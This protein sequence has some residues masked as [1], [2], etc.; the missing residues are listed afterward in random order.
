MYGK[1]VLLLLVDLL[2]VVTSGCPLVVPSAGLSVL[3][4]PY[5]L[6]YLFL[7][8]YFSAGCC[9]ILLFRY[10]YDGYFDCWQ[11]IPFFNSFSN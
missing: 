11:Y 3:P 10:F 9:I 6:P 5:L 2:H 4:F 7:E 8:N 1:H